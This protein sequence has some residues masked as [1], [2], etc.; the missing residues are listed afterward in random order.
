[1]SHL[2]SQ[3][4]S[5]EPSLERLPPTLHITIHIATTSCSK[6]SRGLC[7]PLEVPG[8]CTRMVCSGD[9]NLGQWGSRYVIHAGRH[10]NGKAFRS[11]LLLSLHFEGTNHNCGGQPF[12]IVSSYRY[13][14]RTISS[15]TTCLA[16]GL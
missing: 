5:G 7:F 8:L 14:G 6:V 9:S 3:P 15:R 2:S 16:Y 4:D 11:P 1:M 10:S 13:E 12:R